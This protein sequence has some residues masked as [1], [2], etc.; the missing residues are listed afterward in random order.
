MPARSVR[1]SS[2]AMP[3]IT[4]RR[5][6]ARATLIERFAG[7]DG[8]LYFN[9]G[10][11]EIVLQEE[12]SLDHY[13]LQEESP[14]AFHLH[15]LFVR[16][17]ARSRY[18]NSGY[19]LGGAWARTEL[20]LDFRDSAAAAELDGLYLAGEQQLTDLHLD[21]RHAVP[22]CESQSRF[23]GL[24]RVDPMNPRQNLEGGA[25]YLRKQYDEF[26]SWRLALAA[27]NAGPSAVYRHGGIPPFEET[28]EYV[29]RIK[30]LHRRYAQVL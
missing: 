26:R 10:L 2:F 19:A 14:A 16:Q 23:K 5:P 22:G 20:S 29:R 7:T 25:R 11:G 28:R 13:R 8:G 15:S 18:R 4:S 9:N 17:Q 1:R 6:G 3:P 21:I 12:A 24:L 30:I 27:Y